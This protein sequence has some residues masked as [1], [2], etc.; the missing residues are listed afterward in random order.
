MPKGT[1]HDKNIEFFLENGIPEKSTP[2]ILCF[3][4]NRTIVL[5]LKSR[6]LQSFI[7]YLHDTQ[8]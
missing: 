5:K 1:N 2:L 7:V 6:I 4:L 8:F 3:N